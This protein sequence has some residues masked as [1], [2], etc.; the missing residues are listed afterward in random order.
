MSKKHRF[1]GLTTCKIAEYYLHVP[2]TLLFYI[3][4]QD[5]VKMLKPRNQYTCDSF[6]I[7]KFAANRFENDVQI[8]CFKIGIGTSENTY[9]IPLATINL[10]LQEMRQEKWPR[11]RK[12]VDAGGKKI[13]KKL[14]LGVRK[15][16]YETFKAAPSA[17]L[18]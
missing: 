9:L 4:P 12:S 15:R 2:A 17:I 13:G 16:L 8:R 7:D 18:I 14:R 3:F 11:K 5:Y 6:G 10:H 1:D